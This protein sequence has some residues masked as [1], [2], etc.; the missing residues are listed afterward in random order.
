MYTVL[1]QPS[2]INP[3]PISFQVTP[4]VVVTIPEIEFGGTFV[5]EFEK[6]GGTE[7][8]LQRFAKDVVV[9]RNGR[10]LRKVEYKVKGKNISFLHPFETEKLVIQYVQNANSN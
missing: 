4:Q 9:Y 6:F 1:S 10:R 3:T 7:I 8:T 5:E 2:T